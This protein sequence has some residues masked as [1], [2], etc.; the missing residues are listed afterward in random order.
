M[1]LCPALLDVTG[2]PVQGD[3]FMPGDEAGAADGATAAAQVRSGMQRMALVQ[4]SSHHPRS[5]QSSAVM[6]NP[7]S[8]FYAVMYILILRRGLTSMLFWFRQDDDR[9]SDDAGASASGSESEDEDAA[10]SGGEAASDEESDD[11]EASLRSGDI[12]SG[13]ETDG[14]GDAGLSWE[15]VLASVQ[16]PGAEAAASTADA[17]APEAADA[18]AGAPAA[19][20]DAAAAAVPALP[21]RKGR[22]KPGRY[23]SGKPKLKGGKRKR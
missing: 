1:S 15:A 21:V 7:V 20:Q 17:A 3:F 13:A 2:R 19:Q 4:I 5:M 10:G 8:S 18:V 11:D 14:Y 23:R 12:D 22:K 9:I 16:Q 6:Q